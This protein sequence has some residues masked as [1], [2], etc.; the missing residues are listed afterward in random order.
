M[1]RSKQSILKDLNEIEKLNLNKDQVEL[2]KKYQEY[3]TGTLPF[4]KTPGFITTILSAIGI[5]ITATI[6][7]SQ[8]VKAQDQ[9]L[10]TERQQWNTKY[11]EDSLDLTK[12]KNS[13]AKQLADGKE[14]IQKA[15]YDSLMAASIK[16]LHDLVTVYQE[17]ENAKQQ[18]IEAKQQKAKL[19]EGYKK[20]QIEDSTLSLKMAS[21]K[22]EIEQI[23]KDTQDEYQKLE[24]EKSNTEFGKNRLEALRLFYNLKSEIS[25][26]IIPAHGT[27]SGIFAFSPEPIAKRKAALDSLVDLI[28]DDTF[29]TKVFAKKPSVKSHYEDLC[30]KIKS[31]EQVSSNRYIYNTRTYCWVINPAINQ[32]IVEVNKILY[33]DFKNF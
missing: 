14:K 20:L 18:V 17:I 29:L 32:I 30:G 22:M 11:T 2:V 27:F 15:T 21:Q 4:W 8:F 28:E 5:T 26:F 9:Q 7:Y 3:K 6:G 25:T 12:Q 13:I 33:A 16:H 19:A 10:K 23:K 31:L 1:K 24:E